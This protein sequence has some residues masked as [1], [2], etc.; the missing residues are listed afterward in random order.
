LETWL[1]H[2]A[3]FDIVIWG[4]IPSFQACPSKDIFSSLEAGATNGPQQQLCLR[5]SGRT[6]G[7]RRE[8]CFWHF[9]HNL[10][11]ARQEAGLTW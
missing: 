6:I 8:T 4:G 7:G 3:K 5:G 2:K 10:H 1:T 9:A 11:G